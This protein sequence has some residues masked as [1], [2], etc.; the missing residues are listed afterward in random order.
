MWLAEAIERGQF[1]SD[2]TNFSRASVKNVKMS[3]QVITLKIMSRS[4]KTL[5]IHII[6]A[7]FH[8]E[9]PS[10]IRDIARKLIVRKLQ[11]WEEIFFQYWG[12]KKLCDTIKI[13]GANC[14]NKPNKSNKPSPKLEAYK[15]NNNQSAAK[16]QQHKY[17]KTRS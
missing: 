16:Y 1:H 11:V 13:G 3:N 12:Q 9:S 7:K 6:E 14:I 5:Y 10:W 17:F 8:S 2:R 4:K 15:A